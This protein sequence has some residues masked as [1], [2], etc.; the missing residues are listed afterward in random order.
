ME[1]SSPASSAWF[2][3][4]A[5]ADPERIGVEGT[6]AETDVEMGI[7]TDGWRGPDPEV[8]R[9]VFTF[10]DIPAPGGFDCDVWELFF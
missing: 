6:C 5:K 3:T 7:E 2:I 10:K 9:G 4:G 8:G 1:D